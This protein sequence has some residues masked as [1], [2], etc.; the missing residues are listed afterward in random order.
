MI[1]WPLHVE[2]FRSLVSSEISTKNWWDFSEI[3]FYLKDQSIIWILHY[4]WI[5]IDLGLADKAFPVGD[6]VK[7]CWRSTWFSD[8][9]FESFSSSLMQRIKFHLLTLRHVT[10]LTKLWSKQETW[11]FQTMGMHERKCN[12]NIIVWETN[13]HKKE[14]LRQ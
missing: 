6:I 2:Y 10:C 8:S 1:L 9:E 4:T 11:I 3:T 7:A 12:E 13:R 14:S 5:I